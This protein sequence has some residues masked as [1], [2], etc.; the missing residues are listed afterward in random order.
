M[1]S[2]PIKFL[3]EKYQNHF[4]RKE[5]KGT[6]E[7]IHVDEV[8]LK[9]AR[10]YEKIRNII[11]YREAHLLRKNTILRILQRS[12]LLYKDNKNIAEFLIKEIIRSGHLPNDTIPETKVSEVNAI[13]SRLAFFL[14][15]T[16]REENSIGRRLGAWLVRISAC[17][18]EEVLDPP[19]KD[20]VLAETMFRALKDRLLIK[21]KEIPENDKL[22]QLFLGI[23]RALLK[24]DYDQLEYHLLRLMHPSWDNP[25]EQELKT[26]GANLVQIK[27]SINYH[28]G[29]PLRMRFF[30]L[31]KRYA[32]VFLLLGDLTFQASFF[33]EDP[34]K[35]LEHKESLDLSIYNAYRKRYEHQ[36]KSLK[37]LAVLSVVS[38]FITK[39]L[40]AFAIEI[41]IDIYLAGGYSLANTAVNIAFPPLLLCIILF[42]IP[43]PSRENINLVK[44]EVNAVVFEENRKDY[45]LAIP[46]EKKSIL[47]SF[48]ILFYI[49]VSIAVLYGVARLLLFL[50]FSPASIGVFIIFT[51]I[52]A[53]TGIRVH[54][55]SQELSLEEKKASFFGLLINTVFMP[56][57]TLGQLIITALS[58]FQFLV[59]LINLI[60]VPFQ[61]FIIFIENFNQFIR[62]KREELQ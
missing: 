18:I 50:E 62:S 25:T 29:H 36:R 51:S 5:S 20:R 32:T 56:F 23:E 57:V 27:K 55:R 58:K 2:E 7:T 15:E 31:A 10:F 39:V 12:L 30:N 33:Q 45:L 14:E 59:V 4:A 61:M 60:D 28:I 41:P 13:I 44:K 6:T 48:I 49:A 43:R 52:V 22:T 34:K 40:V 9:I 37:R 1:L 17:A 16:R 21:G 46:K 42:L 38:L 3:L 11:D 54:N 53:A 24:V 26:F 19:I 35:F 47:Q 8:A